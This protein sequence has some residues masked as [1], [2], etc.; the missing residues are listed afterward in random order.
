MH[1]GVLCYIRTRLSQPH[2]VNLNTHTHAH[3]HTHTP[4]N[5]VKNKCAAAFSSYY[6]IINA[7]DGGLEQMHL[8]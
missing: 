1:N 6:Q 7:R 5:Y 4:R 2:F 3:T 8:N